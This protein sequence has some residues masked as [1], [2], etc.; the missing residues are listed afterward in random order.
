MNIG[1]SLQSEQAPLNFKILR[2]VA[3]DQW[4]FTLQWS[5]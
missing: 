5:Y 3:L 2:N 4:S 1:L